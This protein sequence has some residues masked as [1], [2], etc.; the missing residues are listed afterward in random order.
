MAVLNGCDAIVFT[1]GIGENSPIKRKLILSDMEA[2]GIKID[3]T[4]NDGI[5]RKEG[6]ISA[7]GSRVRVLVVPTNE[8]LAIARDTYKVVTGAN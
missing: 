4:I 1:G 7:K 3:D 8:E 6:E 5:I 2:L